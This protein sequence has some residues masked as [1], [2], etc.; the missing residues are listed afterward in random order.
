MF[1]VFVSGVN[2]NR[3][4][5]LEDIKQNISSTLG[6]EGENLE[7]LLASDGEL[8]CI[9][10]N[11]PENQ[12]IK[13]CNILTEMGLL[14]S[15]EVTK[16]TRWDHL[17]VEPSNNPSPKTFICS[18]CEKETP[19]VNGQKSQICPSCKENIEKIQI[20]DEIAEIE[21]LRK[22]LLLEAKLEEQREEEEKRQKQQHNDNA[23]IEEQFAK[24]LDE[25]NQHQSFNFDAPTFKNKYVIP[26]ILLALGLTGLTTYLFWPENNTSNAALL[27]NN[28]GKT[29]NQTQSA[30]FGN[31]NTVKNPPENIG[32]AGQLP[33]LLDISNSI[34]ASAEGELYVQPLISS[35]Q[36]INKFLQSYNLGSQN[37]EATT[38]NRVFETTLYHQLGADI[39]WNTFLYRKAQQLIS[40]KKFK[41]AYLLSQFQT[42]L[43]DQNSIIVK[44]V[45]EYA[46]LSR[47]DLINATLTKLNQRIK[48]QPAEMQAIYSLQLD[49]A[50]QN[51]TN[52]KNGLEEGE[53]QAFKLIDPVKQSMVF[54][55]IA[56][57]ENTLGNADAYNKHFS[58]AQEKLK[59]AQPS[60]EQISGF[61]DLAADYAKV[62]NSL[63]AEVSLILA[64]LS[65][66]K[67]DPVKQEIGLALLLKSA[68]QINN[69]TYIKKYAEL[70]HSA[71]SR[72]KTSFESIELQYHDNLSTDVSKQLSYITNPDFSAIATAFSALLEEDP[73]IQ[74][75][76]F[77]TAI[78]KLSQITDNESK[79]L[80]SSKVARYM[81]RLGHINPAISLFDEALDLALKLPKDQQQDAVL[82]LLADD[83]SK[84]FFTDSA[85]R[86]AH[87]IHDETLKSDT[88][89]ML[90]NITGV[91]NELKL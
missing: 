53:N 86:V 44:L 2:P 37:S 41:S 19:A 40:D 84:V 50:L 17:S 90:G 1:D 55:K 33:S 43:A 4:G 51:I 85:N 72:S 82:I 83:K 63:N 75:T 5:E 8:V 79:A 29:P 15:F 26:L 11:I 73:V 58:L 64:E 3:L 61:I 68:Y 25:Q 14:C 54:S 30:T 39:E 22:N 45:T 9:Q 52:K 47:Q 38:Q 69:A 87:L 23:N 71:T 49:L 77:D 18:V 32:E 35:Y 16:T 67:L 80:A 74:K 56:V 28:T 21:A 48:N 10:E 13:I 62:G 12:A 42:N 76:L 65:L 46:K 78:K 34:P 91:S 27:N 20:Q 36:A 7:M 57:I 60:L 66:L 70:I 89:D 88:L 81:Y 59:E 24:D 31:D 6:I